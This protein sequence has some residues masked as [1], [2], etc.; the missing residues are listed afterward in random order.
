MPAARLVMFSAF[1]LGVFLPIARK[2]LGHGIPA[3]NALS[4]ELNNMLQVAGLIDGE[5][6]DVEAFYSL[7]YLIAIDERDMPIV[8]Q[9]AGMPHIV[10]DTVGRGIQAA[11]IAGPLSTWLKA[12]KKGCSDDVNHDVR[13]V[14]NMIYKDL[15]SR[16]LCGILKVKERQRD[17][18]TFLLEYTP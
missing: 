7:A 14:Y 17:D 15:D 3:S 10:A 5:A 13:K 1:D 4:D 6:S 12:V 2:A 18:N 16:S 9:I 8:I 11:V